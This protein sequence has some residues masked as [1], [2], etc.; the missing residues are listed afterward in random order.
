MEETRKKDSDKLRILAEKKLAWAKQEQQ[1][2]L[3]LI[4]KTQIQVY[5]LDGIILAYEDLLKPQEKESK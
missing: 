4:K 1:K 5:K 3:A 2:G